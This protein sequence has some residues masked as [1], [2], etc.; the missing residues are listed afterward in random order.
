MRQIL[1]KERLK[2]T[3]V[4]LAVALLAAG[5]ATPQAAL[6][7]LQAPNWLPGQPML[8]GN[9][10]IAMWLPVPGAVKYIIY[11]N[12]KKLLESP[13]NQYMGLAPDA[14]GQY[15]YEVTAVDAAGNESP[16]S[17]A[18]TISIIMIKPPTELMSRPLPAEKSVSLRWGLPQGAVITN[19]YRAEKKEGP[20]KMVGSIQGDNYKDSNLQLGVEYWY[21]VSAKD[22]NGKESDK[23]EPHMVILK[24]AAKA[25]EKISI[26][27]V[28][29]PS[30]NVDSRKVIGDWT[31]GDIRYITKFEDGYLA[32]T[33]PR[34]KVIVFNQAMEQQRSIDIKAGVESLGGKWVTTYQIDAL[35][36]RFAVTD[37]ESSQIAM[38]E[39]SGTPLWVTQ[40]AK[41]PEDNEL[42]WEFVDKQFLKARPIPGI[43]FFLDPFTLLVG[44]GRATLIYKI[45]PENGEVI[46]Y[47]LPYRSK[48][49]EIVKSGG[50][51]TLFKIKD[52]LVIAG[53]SLLHRAVAFNPEN[54]EVQY[55]IG[56]ENDGY[57]A[58]FLGINSMLISPVDGALLIGDG[59]INTL[60]AFDPETGKYLYH[61][62][63]EKPVP[64]PDLENQRPLTSFKGFHQTWIDDQG[65][66]WIKD[67]FNNVFF[68]REVMWDKKEVIKKTK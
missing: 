68:I 52:D 36:D 22:I 9:Q 66:L 17:S 10:V 41:P 20:F 29:V 62:G 46:D 64:D 51:G 26:D 2:I 24:E 59:G 67:N 40:P 31:V 4:L 33:G 25:A 60:Q 5:A 37:N 16:R 55:M 35:E 27:M 23:S 15:K 34:N 28:I 65:R 42:V 54:M 58:G 50:I 48:E 43:P 14:S 12:G 13:A 30:K 32:T 6:A 11:L 44:E 7:A 19:L 45:D 63:D 3:G 47:L 8:A 21:A 57:I 18:G 39:I 56:L 38:F 53:E 61:I 49:G 1:R